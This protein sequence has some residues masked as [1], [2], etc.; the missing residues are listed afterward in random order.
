[1]RTERPVN[2]DLTK[3]KFPIMAISSIC[4]RITGVLLFLFLPLALYLLYASLHSVD[5][6][7]AVVVLLSHPLMKIA[8]WL[9]ISSALF[10]LVAG[11]RHLFMDLGYGETLETARSTATSVFVIAA[12]L[13]ILAGVWL[14]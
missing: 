6:F 10:H 14:W 2:L 9:M 1:M 4:H 13:I 7:A 8:V 12:V 5:C 11:I 3:F